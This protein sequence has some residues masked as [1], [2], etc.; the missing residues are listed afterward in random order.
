MP[1]KERVKVKIRGNKTQSLSPLSLHLSLSFLAAKE[2]GADTFSDIV[3]I[4][5]EEETS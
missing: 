3:L 5:S 2:K 4:I 1:S